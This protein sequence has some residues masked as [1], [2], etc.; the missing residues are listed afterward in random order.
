[1]AKKYGPRYLAPEEITFKNHWA[2]DTEY[3]VAGS[4]DNVYTVK[5]TNKGFTCD[6]VGMTMHGKCKHTANIAEQ[7]IT[8]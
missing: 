6:C 2:L 8:A 7:W 1:M 3:T 5:F 4:R